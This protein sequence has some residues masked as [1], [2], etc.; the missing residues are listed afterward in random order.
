[1]IEAV[2]VIL[3]WCFSASAHNSQ[4]LVSCLRAASCS[5]DLTVRSRSG[6]LFRDLN[7]CLSQR[8][9]CP[10]IPITLC[11]TVESLLLIQR[12]K[13]VAES[14]SSWKWRRRSAEQGC[15]FARL[16]HHW[17]FCSFSQKRP[18]CLLFLQANRSFC[19][20][21]SKIGKLLFLFYGAAHFV[22]VCSFSA[23]SGNT[24]AWKRQSPQPDCRRP[25]T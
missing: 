19:L 22:R 17:Y 14:R 8:Q 11:Q 4:E 18:S 2:L 16:A 3:V 23:K 9:P 5:R 1:M 7:S 6:C 10:L 21:S 13:A 25:V 15:V 24:P 20:A 12:R